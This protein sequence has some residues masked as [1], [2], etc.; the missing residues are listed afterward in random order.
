MSE[1]G[2]ECSELSDVVM[3][4]R[5]LQC[6]RFYSAERSDIHNILYCTNAMSLV[7]HVLCRH[8]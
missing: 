8:Q 2:A 1:V 3:V 6:V 7:M 5:L 4:P